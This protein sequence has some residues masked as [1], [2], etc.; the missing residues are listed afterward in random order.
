MDIKIICEIASAH[1]GSLH[2]LKSLI[3]VGHE[4]GADYLKLQIFDFKEF[5]HSKSKKF[6]V[7]KK[8]EISAYEW[9]K[10]F[11][12]CYKKNIDLIAEPY[13]LKSLELIKD[14]SNIKSIKI[15]TADLNDCNFLECASEFADLIFVGLGGAY[16][17]EISETIKYINQFKHIKLIL[18]HGFQNF[19]TKLEDLEL[20]KIKSIK[21]EFVHDVGFADHIN[22][23]C[24]ELA[25]TIPCMAISM[26]AKYIEKHIT[27]N[28]SKK[29]L[30]FYSALNPDEFKDFVSFL[31]IANKAIGNN[32]LEEISE[33]E[34]MYRDNMKK[35]AILNC[36][37]RFGEN[38]NFNQVDF[39]RT[40]EVGLTRPMLKR[41]LKRKIKK[42]VECGTVINSDIFE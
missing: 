15:P 25:R 7:L 9:K 33:A 16:I 19:P 14:Y 32:S 17:E 18:M 8:V 12:Y 6:E 11:D 10:I 3:D 28:R 2:D 37:V 40:D 42:F 22:A 39:K 36:D 4:S 23:E 1:E 30:D 34:K 31:K 41:N 20:S 24:K 38:L 21:N 35:F 29:G 27:L 5:I 13:D 26:G